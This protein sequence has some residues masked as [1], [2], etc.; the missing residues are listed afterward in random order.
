MKPFNLK[1]YKP[2]D[3]IVTRDGKKVRILDINYKNE[4]FPIIGVITHNNNEEVIGLF[5]NDGKFKLDKE[6]AYDL[7]IDDNIENKNVKY[8]IGTITDCIRQIS[9][10]YSNVEVVIKYYK[11]IKHKPDVKIFKIT[12]VN[13]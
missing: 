5:T 4:N 6:D 11:L 13:I 2:T 8:F 12:E 3:K 10:V 1:T 7:F 9:L